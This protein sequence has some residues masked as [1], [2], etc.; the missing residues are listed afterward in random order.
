MHKSIIERH[1]KLTPLTE[2]EI[3]IIATATRLFLEQGFSVTTH[4]QIAKNRAL[5]SEL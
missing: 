5:V 4:R 2:T 3:K 1:N